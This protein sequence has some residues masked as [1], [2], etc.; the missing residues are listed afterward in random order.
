GW[1]RQPL[2]DFL[3]HRPVGLF[4]NSPASRIQLLTQSAR[5]AIERVVILFCIQSV[6]GGETTRQSGRHPGNRHGSEIG[7]LSTGFQSLGGMAAFPVVASQS[8]EGA[9]TN[10][11]VTG[12]GKVP[13]RRCRGSI[14]VLLK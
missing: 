4:R 11:Q 12:T 7:K 2:P 10:L 1:R 5:G 3:S 14:V 13:Q 6:E 9:S 8:C